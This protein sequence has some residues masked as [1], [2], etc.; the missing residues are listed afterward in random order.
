[1]RN[2]KRRQNKYFIRNEF[3]PLKENNLDWLFIFVL[4][5]ALLNDPCSR[6]AA[7]SFRVVTLNSVDPARVMTPFDDSR[8][9]IG[10]FPGIVTFPACPFAVSGLFID[11]GSNKSLTSSLRIFEQLKFFVRCLITISKI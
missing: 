1:L 8:I 5:V 2:P 7:I 10:G 11:D 3:T 4:P 6:H 9:C